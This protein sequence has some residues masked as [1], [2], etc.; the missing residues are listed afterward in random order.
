MNN[1]DASQHAIEWA[2]S[3]LEK[4]GHVPQGQFKPV[5]IMPWSSV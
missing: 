2:Y 1:Q 5:R 3:Y 4:Q